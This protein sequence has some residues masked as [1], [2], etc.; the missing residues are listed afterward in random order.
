MFIAYITNDEVIVCAPETEPETLKLY[1]EEGG[2]NLE[3]YD[4]EISYDEAVA[5]TSTLTIN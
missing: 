3:D 2:R 5:I 1:F 4:R